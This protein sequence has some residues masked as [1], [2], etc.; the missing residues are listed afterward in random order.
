MRSELARAAGRFHENPQDVEDLVQETL[1][2]AWARFG[3]GN[4]TEVN[5]TVW[6]RRTM[7]TAWSAVRRWAETHP[8]EPLPDDLTELRLATNDVAAHP[9]AEV[10]ALRRIVD[11]RIRRALAALPAELSSAVFYADV[12]QFSYREIAVIEGIPMGTVMS[13]IYRARKNLRDAL[14][15]S[16]G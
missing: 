11:I 14:S 9:A 5:A 2:R 6:T 1:T 4:A 8:A 15:A 10:E 7:F 3:G 13:R 12:C 16:A